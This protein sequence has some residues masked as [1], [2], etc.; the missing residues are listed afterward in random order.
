MGTDSFR[1]KG[2]LLLSYSFGGLCSTKLSIGLMGCLYTFGCSDVVQ[3]SL[4]NQFD[5]SEKKTI[6]AKILLI[7][8]NLFASLP[9]YLQ[10]FP[11]N[12]T[13]NILFWTYYL[14]ISFLGCWKSERG[15]P[16]MT[17]LCNTAWPLHIS[18]VKPALNRM[19]QFFT[20]FYW[21]VTVNTYNLSLNM[22]QIVNTSEWNISGLIKEIYYH[23]CLYVA[24]LFYYEDMFIQDLRKC[25]LIED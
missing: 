11:I 15:S 19:H 4:T 25:L 1:A 12:F 22:L 14:K 8:F 16:H 6:I 17:S 18:P 13:L 20:V 24:C 7:L 5:T 3:D 10:I 23:K 21:A 9:L 2:I